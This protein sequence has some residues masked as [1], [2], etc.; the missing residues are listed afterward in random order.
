MF[1]SNRCNDWYAVTFCSPKY[2]PRIYD[3]KDRHKHVRYGF[4]TG[5]NGDILAYAKQA[6]EASFIILNEGTRIRAEHVRADISKEFSVDANSIVFGLEEIAESTLVHWKR[7]SKQKSISERLKVQF[8]VK[9]LYFNGLHAAL[10]KIKHPGVKKMIPHRKDFYPIPKE[11]PMPG[12]TKHYRELDL[13]SYQQRALFA[14]LNCPPGAPIL[15]TGPFGTGKTRLLVR[16]A[17]E[18]LKNPDNR[19]L[20]CAHHQNSVDTFVD[21]F[22]KLATNVHKPWRK[23]F[24]RIILNYS[25][26]SK[27]CSAYPSY[28]KTREDI[29][30]ID[31]YALVMTTLGTSHTL[32]KKG[33]NNFTHILID[34]GA[35]T[36]EPETIS[37]LCFAS[38][39][40]K[41]IIAGDHLQV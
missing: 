37:P 1:L 4:I 22:G 20:I 39:D 27:T 33:R 31:S 29:S 38:H 40:T 25:Y 12:I 14:I 34:E 36:R 11:C 35:Q 13:D 10:N 17:Y 15:I 41:V 19:V 8:E 28:F 18:I 21:Y 3:A 32:R 5:D 7:S 24:V 9:H 2:H 6:S 26:R 16:A 23:K 30:S